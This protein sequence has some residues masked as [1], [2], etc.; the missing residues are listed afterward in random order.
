MRKCL[1]QRE[2]A[3]RAGD[4]A[5][6][7]NADFAFHLAIAKAAKS[8]ALLE[9][10]E[11]FVQSVQPRLESATSADYIRNERDPLHAA[12]CEAIADGDVAETRRL[13]RSHLNKSAK[14]LGNALA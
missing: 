6:Y 8:P 10:Y 12:L 3:I 2:Q 11:S 13:V 1:K 9:V 4:V 5:A 14:D 7:A